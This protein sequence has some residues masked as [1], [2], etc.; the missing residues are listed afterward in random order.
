MGNRLGGFT[1]TPEHHEIPLVPGTFK[2]CCEPS[3]GAEPGS[4]GPLTTAPS[5]LVAERERGIWGKGGKTNRNE[6]VQKRLRLRC[7]SIC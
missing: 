1:P 4:T 3:A 2:R 7:D 5:L 6:T